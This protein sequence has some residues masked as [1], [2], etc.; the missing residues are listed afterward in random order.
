MLIFS[1]SIR[2]L[3]RKE[4]SF[5]VAR[6]E[7]YYAL[8]MRVLSDNPDLI[9]T[10]GVDQLNN[11]ALLVQYMLFSSNLSS[12]WY[13]LGFATRMIIDMGLHRDG[14]DD[15]GVELNRVQ[16]SFWTIYSLTNPLQC[17]QSPL[18]HSR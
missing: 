4:A 1:I 16:W 9:H 12:A 7:A 14:E 15:L 8:A 18:Q 5:P 6:S 3:N 13:L 10:P 11:L 2:S 17:A